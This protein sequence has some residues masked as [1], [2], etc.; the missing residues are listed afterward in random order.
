[1]VVITLTIRQVLLVGEY[2][3]DGVAHLAVI[4]DPV[5]LLPRLVD[6]VAVSAVHHEY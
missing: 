4:Y 2:E 1:M 5:Q 3:Y 6:A